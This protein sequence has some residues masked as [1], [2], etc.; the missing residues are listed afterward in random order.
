MSELIKCCEVVHQLVDSV[1]IIKS[2]EE[3]RRIIEAIELFPFIITSSLKVN[4][5]LCSDCLRIYKEIENR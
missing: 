1:S 2:Q 5:S 3:N 4:N